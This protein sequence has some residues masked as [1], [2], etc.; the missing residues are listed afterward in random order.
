MCTVSWAWRPARDGYDLFFNRDERTGRGP[1]RPPQQELLVDTQVV[2]PADGDHGGTWLAVNEHGL[3]VCILNGYV[4]SRGPEP[5][6]PRSRGLLVRDL[7]HHLSAPEVGSALA[8][9]D[10]SPYPPFVLLAIAPDATPLWS[11]WDGLALESKE[12]ADDLRPIASSGQDQAAAQRARAARYAQLLEEHG[13]VD[14]ALIERFQSDHDRGPSALTACMHRED[15]Q[16]R[17]Q[18]RVMVDA[19]SVELVHV[20]GPPCRTSPSPALTLA[21]RGRAATA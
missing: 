9:S 18:C 17:S 20:P 13:R 8:R 11:R 5:G 10:L 4:A 15:A 19:R 3:T 12:D 21:R 6:T 16:T 2:L 14:R 1:E 7:A